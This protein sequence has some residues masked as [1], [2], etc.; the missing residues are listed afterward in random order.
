M[1]EGAG[2][3]TK[4]AS[5]LGYKPGSGGGGG[6]TPAQIQSAAFISGTD[7]GVADAYVVTLSPSAPFTSANGTAI[8]FSPLNANATTTPTLSVNGSSPLPIVLPNNTDVQA[9]DINT[10]SVAVYV[11]YSN[12]VWLLM[13]PLLSYGGATPT[14]VQQSAFNYAVDTGVADAYVVDYSPAITELTDGLTLLF[15]PANTSTASNLTD[16]NPTIT[17]NGIGPTFIQ[18]N[19][20]GYFGTKFDPF[21]APGDITAGSTCSITYNGYTGDFFINNPVNSTVNAFSVQSGFYNEGVDSGVADAYVVTMNPG[22]YQEYVAQGMPVNFIPQNSNATTT[23]TLNVNGQ[24]VN[25][26]V[27]PNGQP[28]A[29][30]DL[31]SGLTANCL[32]TNS[33]W[34]L[35]NP[36]VSYVSSATVATQAQVQQLVYN[37]GVDSG[38]ADA[39]VLTFT[40][41]ITGPNNGMIVAFNPAYSNLTS[42]PTLDVG[43][44]ALTMYLPGESLV[45][46][47]PGDISSGEICWCVFSELSSSWVILTPAISS[48]GVSQTLVTFPPASADS[49]LSLGSAFHNPLGYDVVLTVYVSVTAATAGTISLGVGSGVSPTQ[50]TIVGSLTTAS[51]LIVPVTIYLPYNYYALLSVGGTI[52]ATIAGQQVMPV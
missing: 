5:A 17:V 50:Q 31:A 33:G 24:G 22:Q 52:T 3:F 42:A 2:D 30:G 29:S 21:L 27:L 9:G 19:D 39:Y 41:A 14:Q 23:P 4:W 44:G 13:N 47:L 11:I 34:T 43:T 49:A 45:N 10:S 1:I 32:W 8:S 15:A 35:L 18:L 51:Q 12:G 36:Q 20:L 7:S 46:M 6:V 16:T 25:P 26:I 40:P 48:F 38:A 28:V 37:L